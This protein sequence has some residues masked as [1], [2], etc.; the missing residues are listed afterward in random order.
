MASIYGDISVMHVTDLLQWIDLTRKSGTIVVNNHGI[1]KKIYLENGS[2]IFVSSNKD[3]E[4]LGEFL[5]RRSYLEQSKIKSALLQSQ[6]MK[7]LFT[8][9]LIELNYFTA[10][11]LK[12]IITKHAKEILFDAIEWKEGRFEFIQGDIPPYVL[13]GTISLTTTELIYKVFREIENVRMGLE[14]PANDI[15]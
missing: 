15:R 10:E 6:A 13:R 2:I 3:G 14:K 1:E 12:D 7:V 5:H 8:Q 11:E 9:R 4:R